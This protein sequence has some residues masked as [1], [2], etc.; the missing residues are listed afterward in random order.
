[1]P[2]RLGRTRASD[3]PITPEPASVGSANI[4]SGTVRSAN[5]GSANVGSATTA[6]V[7]AEPDAIVIEIGELR[8]T[9]L[10]A[11]RLLL[12]TVLVPTA[13]LAVLLH[14]AGLV[15][16]LCAV[17]AWCFLTVA[18]RWFSGR[19]MPGTL[20][21]CVAMLAGR[22][23]LALIM[24]STVVYLLQPALGSVIMA[25]LFLGSAAAGRPV[26]ARLARD[27]VALPAQVFHRPAVRRMFTQV[28][29]VWGGS[30]LVDAG[31][32][33]GL[34]HR[35]VDM[36]LLSRGVFSGVLT[37]ATV[38]VCACWGWRCLRRLPGITLRLR[39]NSA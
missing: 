4:R 27:F 36:G 24:S 11:A 33:V 7:T 30:R 12:E 5:V 34:L 15:A 29:L 14:T 6:L 9:L 17:L 28:S 39:P 31:M 19:R 26:T 13:L 35:G 23:C 37:I 22:S 20:L 2:I 38:V 18:L 21:L 32:S 10:R 16:G 1:M 8:P 3:P 25:I